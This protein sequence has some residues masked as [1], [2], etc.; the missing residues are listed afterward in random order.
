M[1]A[2]RRRSGFGSSDRR[3][4]LLVDA[5][6]QAP[7]AQEIARSDLARA[8]SAV[9]QKRIEREIGVKADMAREMGQALFHPAQGPVLAREMVDQHD[10]AA[11]DTDAPHL[12]G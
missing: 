2:R 8:Q 7:I 5:A 4:G 12:L 3:G 9:A 11:G 10:R 1:P 6:Q